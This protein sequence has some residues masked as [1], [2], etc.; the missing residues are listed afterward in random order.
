[1]VIGAVGGAAVFAMFPA[2]TPMFGYY[3]V[4]LAVGFFAYV[5]IYV[6]AIVTTEGWAGLVRQS[7]EPNPVMEARNTNRPI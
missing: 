7:K 6:F 3:G 5:L 4:G 1:V 2:Q